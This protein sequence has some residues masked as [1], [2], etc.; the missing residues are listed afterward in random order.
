MT[1]QRKKKL[2]P[3]RAKRLQ[4]REDR[5]ADYAATIALMNKTPARERAK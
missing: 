4:E 3:E 1:R 2:S 5:R